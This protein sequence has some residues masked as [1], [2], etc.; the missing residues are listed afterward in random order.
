M[1]SS[2]VSLTRQFKFQAWKNTINNLNHQETKQLLL[3]AVRQSIP[4]NDLPGQIKLQ[5]LENY[6]HSLKKEKA[7]DILLQVIRS[8]LLEIQNF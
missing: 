4:T 6:I 3:I 2:T 8:H 5:N 7:Q 1:S